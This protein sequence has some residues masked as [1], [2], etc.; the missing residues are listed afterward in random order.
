MRLGQAAGSTAMIRTFLFLPV[1]LSAAKGNDRPAKLEPPP[2]Q[3]MTMSG[4]IVRLLELLL[5]LEA[6]DGLVQQH[7]VEHAAER[8]LRVVAGGG[9]LHGLAD[10][11]AERA[12]R[13]R[14]PL[15]DFLARLRVG[16]GA[17]HDLST[18]RLHHDPAIGLLLV[19]DLDHVHLALQSEHADTPAPAPSPTGPPRSRCVS[20]LIPF[21]L[22]V[23]RLRDG[24]VRLVAAGRADALV[25]VVDVRRRAERFLETP[26]AVQRRR[27]PQPIDV[28]NLVRDLDPALA[29]DLLLD[30]LHREER[31]EIGRADRLLGAGMQDRR[32]RRLEVSLDVVPLGGNVL[33]VEHELRAVAVDLGCHNR[34]PSRVAEKGPGEKCRHLSELASV[35]QSAARPIRELTWE[36]VTPLKC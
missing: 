7:V 9:V 33:L 30:Q 21:F 36:S 3:P 34:P 11:D 1:S 14:I 27:A 23:V 31:R 2:T 15:Q 32:R 13:V 4:R 26:G 10:G 28:A 8:V 5:G 12:G 22:V 17:R 6:D 25:L 29:A 16:A 19:A 20:R 35:C 18:P 24:G